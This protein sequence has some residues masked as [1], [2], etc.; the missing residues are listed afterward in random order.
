[1]NYPKIKKDASGNYI[2]E[3]TFDKQFT[4]QQLD[5]IDIQ[6]QAEILGGPQGDELRK[7]ISTNP[8]ASAG[9]ISGLYKNGSIGSSDLVKTFAQIDEQTKAQRELD[10]LKENQKLSDEAFKSKFWGLPYNIWKGIKG[11]SR[12]AT[13]G[14]LL[15]VESIYNSISNTVAQVA[16]GGLARPKENAVWEGIDQ[17]Y[18][19]QAI[20]EFFTTGEIN[21]GSGFFINEETGLGFKVRQEK[22]KLGKIAVLDNDGKQVLDKEGNPLYRPYSAIDPISYVMTGGNLEGGVA[23]LINAIGEIGFLVYA[24]PVTKVNKL[25]KAKNAIIKSEAYQKGRATAEDLQKLTVLETQIAANADDTVKALQELEL[26]DKFPD[27]AKLAPKQK[28]EF[29]K[30]FEDSLTKAVKLDEESQILQKGIDYSALEKF[31]NGASAK[32]I[33]NEI[34]EIDDWFDVWQLSRRGGKAGFTKDQSI[35]LAAA[36][37]REEVLSALAPYIANGTVVQNVLESGTAASRAL[38]GVVKGKQARA[39]QAIAG[40]AASGFRKIPYAEKLYN[41]INKS[42]STYIPR[43]GALVHFEDK[44]GLIE[45]VTNF[46]RALKVDEATVKTL[47]D[48]IAFNIDPKVSAFQAATKVYDEVFKA[49]AAAFEKA[50]IST[51]KLKDLTTFFK[52]N[53][54]EQAMYWAEMHRNGANLDFVFTN[55]QKVR[56]NGPHLESERLNSMLYF[57]PAEELLREIAKVGKLKAAYKNKLASGAIDAV[58]TFTSNYWKKILLTRPAYV[59]RNIGEEQIRIMLNGHIS[60]Y[61]NPLAAIAMW[62]GRSSGPKWRQILNTFDKH[63]NN[64]LGQEMKLAKSADELA[65]ESLANS[66]KYD[67]LDFMSSMS[68]GAAQEVN[69][70]SIMRGYQL[71]YPKDN[72]WYLGLANEIRILSAS[73][74]GKAVAR[75]TPGNEGAT[76]QYFLSGQ[77]RPAWDRFLNGIENKETRDIFDTYDG[78]MAFLFTGKNADKQLVSL[79]ARIEQ[80]AGQNGASAEAIRKLIGDGAIETS[81]YSLRVPKETDEALNSLKNAKEVSS[82]RKKIKDVNE[83]FAKQLEKAFSGVANWDNVAMKVPKEVAV[84]DKSRQSKINLAIENFFDHAVQFEKTTSMGPEWRQ[85]YWDVVR[86]VIYAADAPALEQITKIAPKSLAPLLNFDGT[87]AIGQTHGFWANVKKADGSGTMTKEEIHEYASRVASQHVKELFYNASKKRL[88]WHQLRLIAPFGQAWSDTI[89]KWGKLSLNNPGEVYKV[90]RALDFLKSPESSALYQLT[91]AKDYYDPNQGFFFTDPQYGVR[92]FYVPFMSTGMNFFTNLL[93]KGQFSVEG[94]FGSKGTPQSF[95][96]ALGSGILPGFGPGFTITLNMLEGFGLDPV[97][98]LPPSMREFAEKIFF[99]YGRPNITTAPG[100][101]Q[102]ATTPNISRIASSIFNFE[103]GYAAAFAPTMNYLASGGDYNL[104]DPKD[105]NRL[106]KDTNE[107]SRIFAGFRGV[108]GLGSP[109]ATSPEDLVK[110]KTGNAMLASALWNDFKKFEIAAGGDRNKAYAEFLD[111]YG[112]EQVFALVSTW[113]GAPTN[114]LTYRMIL[115]DPSVVNDYQD[116]FGY[117]Y[118]NGG[119]SMELR[120][121]LSKEGMTERLSTKEIMDR[122]TSIRYAA[123]K[124]RLL[125]KSV[126]EQ[127]SS[128]TTSAALSNLTDSFNLI[129]KKTVFDASK[130][131]RILNQLRKASQD[132]RFLNS[133][134]VAGIRDYLYLRDETL[135][136][137]GKKPNESLSAKGFETQ[138]TYLAEQALEIIKRNPDFQKIFYIFFKEELEG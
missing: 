56:F 62:Q 117:F 102:A 2:I 94:P 21:A 14:L 10:Q 90:T 95:N 26:F 110:D 52:K 133:T 97:E 7:T 81:G 34:A 8:T 84:I 121:F 74:L 61:N 67:Y 32:P 112:P 92:Q 71:V 15:P 116:T 89:L 12:L 107:F 115:K 6:Q 5:Y 42:Y 41:G 119:F 105:Q 93:D 69:K 126:G 99:P 24:D 36:K 18:A 27:L 39:A 100:L 76:V 49:N 130:D 13:A 3:G 78:A 101:L 91:D 43:D 106:I 47:V 46:A 59:I 127:W 37:T 138:R 28:E 30:A 44:D 17:T 4:Q 25:I 19:V 40:R 85:K 98:K 114:L 128:K 33:I 134:A 55:G 120:N 58:D 82:G 22:L 124:D 103:E 57:P 104:D 65:Y 122:A 108:F 70:V 68:Q 83:E 73:N 29:R 66:N 9:I 53:A 123:A 96:F 60:F 45:V 111:L 11:T 72:N 118:P 51:E 63:K 109:F 16:T 20:K 86:D 80:V 79:Q 38:S 113:T 132:E 75:T 87:K 137:N 125:A 1:V 129:G 50:G 35:A 88:L 131:D 23:R 48:D 77:G 64:V 136:L 135:R 31:L 54:D